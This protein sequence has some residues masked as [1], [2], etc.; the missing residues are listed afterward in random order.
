M[1]V[2]SPADY[3]AAYFFGSDNPP[4]H[5]AG[6]SRFS[7]WYRNDLNWPVPTSGEY[8]EDVAKLYVNENNLQTRKVLELGCTFGWIIQDMR[9]KY[10]VD[11]WGVEADQGGGAS[12]CKSQADPA[13][14]PYIVIGNVITTSLK[15]PPFDWKNNEF[16]AI[17]GRGFLSC[18]DPGDIQ[19]VI[20]NISPC[21]RAFFFEIWDQ[22]IPPAYY[23]VQSLAWW[24][25]TYSWPMRTVLRSHFTGQEIRP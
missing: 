20:D 4:A 7:R 14:Q 9:E 22:D 18:L 12:Y 6:Y 19:A 1:S 15:D 23:T 21:G 3:N 17:L 24:A 10:G 5:P 8:W 25:S 16:D 11:A 13:I 2:L